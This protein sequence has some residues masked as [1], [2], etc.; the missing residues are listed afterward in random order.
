[1]N[2][3]KAATRYL[4]SAIALTTLVPTLCYSYNSGSPALTQTDSTASSKSFANCDFQFSDTAH[5]TGEK[6]TDPSSDPHQGGA[7]SYDLGIKGFHTLGDQVFWLFIVD[8]TGTKID[9]AISYSGFK[10]K[11]N[12]D[13]SFTGHSFSIGKLIKYQKLSF[14]KMDNDH[15][16]TLIGRQTE[17]GTDQT[18]TPMTFEAVHVLRLSPNYAISIDMPF[19]PSTLQ[20][21]RDEVVKDLVQLVNSVHPTTAQMPSTPN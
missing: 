11:Q 16:I 19:D 13:W 3:K 20:V 9:Q 21:T 2:L 4:F 14:D 1:M 7:C 5:V 17:H 12:G 10:K 15:D 6:K 8:N 18:G